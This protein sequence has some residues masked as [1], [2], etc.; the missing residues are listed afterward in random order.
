MI[1]GMYV[2]NVYMYWTVVC[3]SP[4]SLRRSNKWGYNCNGGF[5]KNNLQSNITYMTDHN[6]TCALL[7]NDSMVMK[8]TIN[9]HSS[10][11][12]YSVGASI[13]LYFT[14]IFM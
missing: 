2:Y 14:I 6:N 9:V 10:T 11:L 7:C 13:G 1:V 8:P 5:H 4:M 3:N 12:L